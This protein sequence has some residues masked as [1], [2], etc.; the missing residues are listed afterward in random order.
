[1]GTAAQVHGSSS[2]RPARPGRVRGRRTAAASGLVALAAL[3]AAC[4]GVGGSSGGPGGSGASGSAGPV[5]LTT[6][7]FGLPDELATVRVDAAKKATGDD[8]K[9]AEGGFDEQQFLSAVASN[10]PPDLVYLDRNDVGTYAARGAIQPLDDC[11]ASQKIDMGQF[12]KPAVDS[13]TVRGKVYGIPEFSSVRLVIADNTALKAAG[14]TPDDVSKADWPALVKANAAMTKTNGRKVSTIGYDAKLPAFLPL[15][16]AAA[17][18]TLVSADGSK[19]QLD[20]PALVEAVANAKTMVDANGGWGAYSSFRN[21]WDFFGAKNE[22]VRHQLGAM[23][24]EDWY[25]NALAG[26][27]PKVDISV[28]PLKN[29]Q[30][31]PV[32]VAG[33]QA[34][35]VPKGAKHKEQACAFATAMTA[36]DTWVTAATAKAKALRAKGNVY[37]GSFTGNV[38]ADERIMSTVYEPSGIKALDD[39]VKVIEQLQSV[40]SP[41]PASLAGRPV[42]TAYEQAIT[43][44]MEGK[45]T[46]RA[47]MAQA[48]KEAQ[49]ALDDAAAAFDRQGS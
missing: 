36:T 49:K 24:M 43:R 4:G 17:G 7:G 9:I 34:W 1:M 18:T 14:L 40:V 13:V 45:Q 37:T 15:W 10:D 8:V 28:T 2:T 22:F 31:Q 41:S 29:A 20:Q 16:A 5:T 21:S 3:T 25:V 46:P 32:T 42:T 33:G 19:A 48:Q 12:R 35:A 44:V 47:A 11:V 30:G 27:S 6:F 38:A 23:P 26:V 39:G